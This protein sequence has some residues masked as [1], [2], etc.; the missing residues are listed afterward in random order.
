M[1]T[2]PPPAPANGSHRANGRSDRK[3]LLVLGAGG[4]AL[5]GVVGF[6]VLPALSPAASVAT[7]S[8]APAHSV[9]RVSASPTAPTPAA[10]VLPPAFTG[11]VGR[12]PFAALVSPPAPSP[13]ATAPTPAASLTA[14]PTTPAPTATALPTAAATVSAPTGTPVTLRLAKVDGQSGAE[15]TLAG[16]PLHLADGQ[17]FHQVFRLLGA[18]TTSAVFQYG[19]VIFTLSPGQSRTFLL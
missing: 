15:V 19:E 16:T 8:V 7:G 5:I 10:A 3:M 18:Q 2:S 14:T 17:L 4:A 1:A 13:T 12:D 11:A 9:A 6:V